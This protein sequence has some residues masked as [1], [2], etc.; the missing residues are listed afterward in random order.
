MTPTLVKKNNRN[1]LDGAMY[2]VYLDLRGKDCL[3]IGG[4]DVATR[5]A[6]TLLNFGANVIV[7]APEISQ[8]LLHLARKN[9]IRF[10]KGKYRGDLVRGKTLIVAA[11]DDM[12]VNKRVYRDATRRNILVNVVDQKQLCTFVAP[13]IVRRGPL[14][15]SISTGGAAPMFSRIMRERLEKMFGPEYASAVRKFRKHR[16]MVN[17]GLS[18]MRKKRKYWRKFIGEWEKNGTH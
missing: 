9:E 17:P 10:V 3:I 12:Q 5:K 2:P 13:S 14:V 8:G 18:T 16:E 1:V 4:G 7:N 15:I 11:T 6:Q